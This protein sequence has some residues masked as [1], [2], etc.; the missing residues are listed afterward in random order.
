MTMSSLQAAAGSQTRNQQSQGKKET[1]ESCFSAGLDL[2]ELNG[3]SRS[4]IDGDNPPRA[5]ASAILL[6]EK[7]R[8][9]MHRQLEEREEIKLERR[10]NEVADAVRYSS[11]AERHEQLGNV[12][13]RALHPAAS[14]HESATGVESTADGAEAEGLAEGGCPWYNS[15]VTID[16]PP[17][18]TNPTGGGR[19][20]N[21]V[22]FRDFDNGSSNTNGFLSS[23]V[24]NH[25]TEERVTSHRSRALLKNH[26]KSTKGRLQFAGGVASQSQRQQQQQGKHS[27]GRCRVSGKNV[28][29]KS[30][31]SKY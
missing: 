3:S 11:A 15:D 5:A 2:S 29:K 23:L 14:N 19:E 13:P 20:D 12:V 4:N 17:A 6:E 16:K 26:A 24:S 8:E 31:K 22:Q 18:D 7:R 9:A 21:F 27:K 25:R 10:M 1:F 28:A 30:R